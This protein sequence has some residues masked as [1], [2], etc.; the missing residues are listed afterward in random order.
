MLLENIDYGEYDFGSDTEEIK[1]KKEQ[2]VEEMIFGEEKELYENKLAE[3]DLVEK[4]GINGSVMLYPKQP[5]EK[6]W[7]SDEYMEM[8]NRLT[9]EVKGDEDEFKFVRGGALM[10]R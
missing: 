1:Q 8:V 4:I 6:K 2:T 5:K 10:G 7:H 9:K 3:L